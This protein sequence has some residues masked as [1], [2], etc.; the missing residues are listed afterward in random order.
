MTPPVHRGE[1][2]SARLVSGARVSA[3]PE[4][5]ADNLQIPGSALRAPRNDSKKHLP[6]FKAAAR[7]GGLVLFVPGCRLRCSDRLNAT[8]L[9][10]HAQEN[11]ATTPSNA[12][13]IRFLP[14]LR[15]MV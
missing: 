5:R 3:N 9:A 7:A 2:L 10:V 13:Q 6:S 14:L 15:R 8:G 1:D 4:S 12:F 11:R